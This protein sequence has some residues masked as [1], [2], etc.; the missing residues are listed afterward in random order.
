MPKPPKKLYKSALILTL[1]LVVVGTGF[2]A[3][4]TSNAQQGAGQ[5][6]EISPPVLTLTADPG[7]T[8]RTRVLIRNVASTDL[9]V[10]G[11]SND[12][13]AEGEGGVPKILLEEEDETSPYSMKDWIVIPGSVRLVPREIKAMN[14][15]IRVPRDASPGGHYGVIRFTGTPPN[16]DGQGV[17]LSASLGSLIL[18]SVSGDITEQLS[19]K[20]FSVNKGGKTGNFFES[21]P[22][23]L[24]QRITNNGNIHSSPAAA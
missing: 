3:V 19:V 2:F 16:L 6:L 4:K 12:F 8:L 24:V 9:I 18:L 15:T 10:T 11:E 13:V 22:L 23:N 7:E 14:L 1:A 20:E 21:T 5:A 17:S